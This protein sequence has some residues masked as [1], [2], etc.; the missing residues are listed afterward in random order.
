MDMQEII[1]RHDRIALQFSGGRDSLACL[2]LMRPYWEKLTVYWCDT[3]AAYP[4]TIALMQQV[5]DMVP[6]FAVIEGRQPQVVTEFGIPSDI[7]PVNATP[8]GRFVGGEA[9]LI[10][11][12]YSC[13]I[14]S[15]MQPTLERMLADGITLIIRGQKQK[16]RLKSQVRSGDVHDG[17]EYLFPIEEWDTRKV[18]RFLADEGATIPRFYEMLN[19][20][21]DCMT[22]SAWWEE[23]SAKYL[24]RYHHA[25]YLEN[26]QRLDIINKAVGEH[27][28]AFNREV[29]A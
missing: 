2:Y 13:C 18:M 25:Q 10:Q 12:R 5:R 17:V 19:G 16:D 29:N 8:I 15:M 1:E 6:N 28:A 9:P 24:K 7:V 11:D 4:E 27:I 20:M 23:G 22:C 21:P 14:R 26:Q 3:G